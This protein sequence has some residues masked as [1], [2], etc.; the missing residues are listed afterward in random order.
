VRADNAEYMPADDGAELRR[1][2]RRW[3]VEDCRVH[4]H[5]G[6][7]EDIPTATERVGEVDCG[8]LSFDDEQRRIVG[9]YVTQNDR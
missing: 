6:R 1:G 7:S 8:S 5:F 9:H 2:D 3:M 4:S